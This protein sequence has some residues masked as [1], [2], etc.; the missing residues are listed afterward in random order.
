MQELSTRTVLARKRKIPRQMGTLAASIQDL[1]GG[2]WNS[3]ERR[4]RHILSFLLCKTSLPAAWQTAWWHRTSK[5][6]LGMGTPAQRTFA[7]SHSHQQVCSGGQPQAHPQ[8]ATHLP[9]PASS[10]T[11]T[12]LPLLLPQHTSG[13]NCVHLPR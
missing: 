6:C 1:Q 11:H 12:S 8:H 10:S 7:G 4:I 9:F 3:H 5:A 13:K 2:S